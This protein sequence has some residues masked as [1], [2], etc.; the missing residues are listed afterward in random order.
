MA[1]PPAS[2]PVE[3]VHSPYRRATDLLQRLAPG[4]MRIGIFLCAGCP[5][6]VQID[7]GS[8][9]EPLIPDLTGVTKLVSEFLDT[10]I[11]H[12]LRPALTSEPAP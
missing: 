2:T 5:L 8:K 12:R 10:Q 1:S 9:T 6:A 11:M 3:P 7:V 4:K